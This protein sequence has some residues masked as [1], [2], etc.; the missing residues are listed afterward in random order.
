MSD[1]PLQDPKTGRFLPGNGGNGG[2]HKGARNRLHADFIQALLDHFH[3][4]EAPQAAD[5][6]PRGQ[7][8]I[9]IV[10]REDPRA[11][12]KLIASVLPKEYSIESNRFDDVGDDE[13]AAIINDLRQK[14]FERE[15]G[16]GTA[17][18]GSGTAPAL[19]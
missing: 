6:L 1:K 19:N 9:E 10:F 17:S 16:E 3:M 14:A 12:L 18:G 11:Y 13:L 5:S 2:R 4:R 8:A 15:R 7:A